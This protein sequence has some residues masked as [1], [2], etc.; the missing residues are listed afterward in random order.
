MCVSRT[1]TAVKACLNGGCVW[2]G[3]CVATTT[4]TTTAATTTT[5][6]ARSAESIVRANCSKDLLVVRRGIK[7]TAGPP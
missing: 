4:T 1:V 7:A 6:E 3:A 5:D 2:G